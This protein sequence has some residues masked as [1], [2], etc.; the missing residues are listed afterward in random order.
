M[1]VADRTVVLGRG[2][3]ILDR[4]NNPIGFDVLKVGDVVEVE[5]TLQADGSVLA[6]KI[7]LQD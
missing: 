6:E 3:R 5:G 2:A 1:M 4:S 7:K